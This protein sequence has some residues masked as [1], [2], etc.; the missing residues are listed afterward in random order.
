MKRKFSNELWLKM[1]K[2]DVIYTGG[3]RGRKEKCVTIPEK[4]LYIGNEA[5]LND[6]KLRRVKFP[7]KCRFIG[8][9]AFRKCSLEKELLFP[10]TVEFLMQGC[11]AQNVH[12]RKVRFPDSLKRMDGEAFRECTRLCTAV[13]P[14]DCEIRI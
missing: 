14:K 10:E 6:V 7:P 9:N 8:K 4:Y 11:F 2:L 13:F 1:H 3:P 5:F 12:L